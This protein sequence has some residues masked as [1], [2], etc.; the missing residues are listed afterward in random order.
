MQTET[1]SA[2][3]PATVDRRHAELV[4]ASLRGRGLLPPEAQVLCCDVRTVLYA[5]TLRSPADMAAVQAAV[6]WLADR[7][8]TTV[9]R[10]GRWDNA[11]FDVV[12]ARTDEQVGGH[13]PV[14]V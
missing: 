5:S 4:I 3:P 9:G 7:S 11:K 12:M 1:Y 10:Y 14:A 13:A 2:G 6:A 8:I